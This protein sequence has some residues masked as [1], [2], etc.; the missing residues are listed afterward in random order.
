[1]ALV[2][3]M[4][5]FPGYFCL[6][7]AAA[8]VGAADDG[9]AIRSA[10][11]ALQRGDFAA[12]EQILRP[13]VKAHPNDASALTLLGVA[14]DNQKKFQEAEDLHRRA[15]ANAPNSTDVWSNYAN[16]LLGAGDEAGAGRLYLK[17]VA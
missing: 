2:S 11:A 15:A 8:V 16:H 12:A 7:L 4:Q 5:R 10:L 6:V 1:M 3:S 17:V 9:A 14:L 13:E